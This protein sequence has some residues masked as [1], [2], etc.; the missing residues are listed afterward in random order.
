MKTKTQLEKEIEELTYHS[1]HK[2]CESCDVCMT[3]ME[4]LWLRKTFIQT[5]EIIEIID[6]M[7]NDNKEMTKEMKKKG[8]ILVPKYYDI[9]FID[10]KKLKLR[11]TGETRT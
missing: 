3:C 9:P 8:K 5:K 6:E 4:N 7:L 1:T 11:L 10:G 2:T